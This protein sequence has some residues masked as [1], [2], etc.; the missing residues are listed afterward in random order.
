MPDHVHLFFGM[1]P[2]QSLSELMKAVKGDSSKW[3]N[4][5]QFV[6]GRF[7]WQEGYG[8]FSYSKSQVPAVIQYVRN[9]KQHHRDRTFIDEYHDLLK[10]FGVPF[11]E[12][13]SFSP[14]ENPSNVDD[15][16]TAMPTS[17]NDLEPRNPSP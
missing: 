5:K 10:K 16:D 4:A 14:V 2:T 13:Y 11:E 1:R 17:P 3:I 8:A 12:R 15:S 6:N 9:Q 7:S